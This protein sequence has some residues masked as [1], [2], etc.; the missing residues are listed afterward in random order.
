[1]ASNDLQIQPRINV[2]IALRRDRLKYMGEV[3]KVILQKTNRAQSCFFFGDQSNGEEVR[4]EFEVYLQGPPDEDLDAADWDT[5]G[6]H[7]IILHY[8]VI[9]GVYECYKMK[10]VFDSDLLKQEHQLPTRWYTSPVWLTTF[11]DEK[12]IENTDSDT[13]LDPE[14][15][16]VEVDALSLFNRYLGE[17]F[18]NHY[19]GKELYPVTLSS[20]RMVIRRALAHLRMAVRLL[21]VYKRLSRS[22]DFPAL[23]TRSK[24]KIESPASTRQKRG[25][26]T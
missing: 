2:D 13:E 8:K 1:M 26:R 24:R 19:P 9:K 6:Y 7:Y 25:K 15:I 20:R 14:P 21:W 4:Q 10:I 17:T 22:S 23:N 16:E 3:G 5:D 18:K 12:E 11:R